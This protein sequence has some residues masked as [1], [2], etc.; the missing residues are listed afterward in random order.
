M[1]TIN[2]FLIASLFF[3]QIICHSFI[4]NKNISI[5]VKEV[6]EPSLINVYKTSENNYTILVKREIDSDSELLWLE[7]D[8]S[9]QI[10]YSN[11]DFHSISPD[12]SNNNFITLYSN[13]RYQVSCFPSG[14]WGDWILILDKTNGFRN[15]FCLPDMMDDSS[16]TFVCNRSAHSF[17][18]TGRHRVYRIKDKEISSNDESVGAGINRIINSDW[19]NIPAETF[20]FPDL[21]LMTQMS[22]DCSAI[23]R[24]GDNLPD[25]LSIV[26]AP[27]DSRDT[28]LIASYSRNGKPL[29]IY[30]TLNHIY[31]GAISD[32]TLKG[33]Y[34]INGD[35]P[36]CLSTEL[37]NPQT[38]GVYLP[39]YRNEDG[40][41]CFFDLYGNR[42]MLFCIKFT[43]QDG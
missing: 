26:T 17:I 31:I 11:T 25:I 32:G 18:L 38:H 10:Q 29:F 30:E 19:D 40:E 6:N 28:V 21:L 2:V 37:K 3:S 20:R 8:Q 22:F 33:K 4:S 27:E 34:R 23:K 36:I 5:I 15:L 35:S 9:H 14:E 13:S 41:Y 12:V 42:M 43:E 1:R 16:G 24:D 7:I 39:A